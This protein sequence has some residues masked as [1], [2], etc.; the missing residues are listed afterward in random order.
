MKLTLFSC[1]PQANKRSSTAYLSQAIKAGI[2]SVK[3]NEVTIYYLNERS[4]WKEYQ[5]A[6][7][8]SKDVMFVLPLYVECIPGLMM[9]FLESLEAK[10]EK[11][12]KLSF[13]IQGGFE[14]AHQLRTAEHFCEQLPKYLNCDYGGTLIK[15]GMFGL[16]Y[17]REEKYKVKCFK[18]FKEMGKSFGEKGRFDKK[19]VNQFAGPEYYSKA[20]MAVIKLVAPI[21]KLVWNRVGKKMGAKDRLD[22]RPYEV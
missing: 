4:R 9:E 10:K 1:S 2:E 6:F 18:A 3:Q 20:L 14:E 21:N 7:A 17:F 13:V 8:E 22:A 12:T 19:E 11:G 15:G 16:A 5:R